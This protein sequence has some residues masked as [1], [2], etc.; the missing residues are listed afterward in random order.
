MLLNYLYP[1]K[2]DLWIVHHH[3]SFNRGY[4]AELLDVDEENNIV[5]IARNGFLDLLPKEMIAPESEYHN[6]ADF[7]EVRRRINMTKEAFLPIDVFAFRDNMKVEREAAEI[8]DARFSYLLK[9]YFG[10]DLEEIHNPYLKVAV[11]LLPSVAKHRGNLK[12]VHLLLRTVMKR[13]VEMEVM[14]SSNVDYPEAWLPMVRYDI[15]AEGLDREQY[16]KMKGEVNELAQFID[17]WYIGAE[18]ILKIRIR[19]RVK[20][21]ILGYNI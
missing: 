8:L 17:D 20:G 4:N 11:T 18:V 16:L 2:T 1:E 19:S 21:N 15:I 3:G 13:E 5:E 6:N 7:E 14:K 10:I 9:N 12:Y